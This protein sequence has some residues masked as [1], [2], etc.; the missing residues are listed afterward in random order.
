MKYN[1]KLNGDKEVLPFGG[2]QYFPDGHLE[3]A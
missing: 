2:G 3:A 1:G